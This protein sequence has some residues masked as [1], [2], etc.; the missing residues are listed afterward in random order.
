[1]SRGGREAGRVPI[2]W[3]PALPLAWA[4]CGSASWHAKLLCIHSCEWSKWKLYFECAKCSE[5]M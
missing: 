4:G 2:Q 1:M 5:K 3:Q